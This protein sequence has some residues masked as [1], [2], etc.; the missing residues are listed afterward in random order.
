MTA[1]T[2]YAAL[3]RAV[4]LGSHNKVAMGD[5]RELLADLGFEAPR[6]LLQSGNLVFRAAGKNPASL[7]RLL[8]RETERR[9]GLRTKCFVRTGSELRRVIAANPFTEEAAADP[10]HLL[11]VFHKGR[12]PSA[13]LAAL[14]QAITG[15]ER[16]AASGREAYLVYP[17]GIG[18]SRVTPSLI[19]KSLGGRGTGRNWNTVLK[20]ASLT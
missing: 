2:S 18:R 1:G 3:L 15:C 14:R 8:E 17:D 9:L 16:V 10:S 5:L 13:G 12:V 6:S 4:N 19:E 7:E 11:V 20:L